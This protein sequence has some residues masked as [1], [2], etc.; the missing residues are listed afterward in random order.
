[1]NTSPATAPSTTPTMAANRES[2]NATASKPPHVEPSNITT[3]ATILLVLNDTSSPR[4]SLYL[5]LL[6]TQS[7]HPSPPAPLPCGLSFGD[8]AQVIR[9]QPRSS[10]RE[11]KDRAQHVPGPAFTSGCCFFRSGAARPG[12][13]TTAAAGTP[14]RAPRARKP[15]G[16]RTRPRAGR[17]LPPAARPRRR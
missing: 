9:P 1:M 10:R 5:F 15:P 11:M 17:S 8:P 7:E 16:R 6:L 14:S 4:L 2:V 12:R 13:Q 3:K